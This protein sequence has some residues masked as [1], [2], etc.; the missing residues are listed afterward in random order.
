MVILIDIVFYSSKK[1]Y[2]VI[3]SEIIIPKQELKKIS[4][5]NQ[6]KQE[7]KKISQTNQL[8]FGSLVN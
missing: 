2:R 6:L 4:Q 3:D 8:I 1:Y 5:T 7:L